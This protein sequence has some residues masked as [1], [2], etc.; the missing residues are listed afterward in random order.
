MP[1]LSSLNVLTVLD[2]AAGVWLD[3]NGL[4]TSSRSSKDHTQFDPPL[5][6]MRRCRHAAA[7][8]GVRIYIYGGL[9]GGKWPYLTYQVT[10]S[11]TVLFKSLVWRYCFGC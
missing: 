2:T 7:S 6:M 11:P 4:V 5:E 1:L 3:R 10:C 8:V 9:R